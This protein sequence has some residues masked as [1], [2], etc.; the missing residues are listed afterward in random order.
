FL[1]AILTFLYFFTRL[2]NLTLLPIFF[3]EANYIFWAKQITA[4]NAHWF[5]PLSAVKPIPLIWFIVT[6]LKIFP[7]AD[8]LLAGRLPSVLLGF[9]TF[10]GTYKLANFLFGKRVAF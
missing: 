9:L 6:F 4:T 3:D 5:L 7:S 2:Y 1:I 8:Y 10:I